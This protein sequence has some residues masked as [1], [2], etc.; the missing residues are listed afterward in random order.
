MSLI[1]IQNIMS[2]CI[3]LA[4]VLFID[5][6]P[7]PDEAPSEEQYLLLFA[8]QATNHRHFTVLKYAS[9]FKYLQMLLKLS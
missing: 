9:V 3:D 1:T 6:S 4:S 2:V 5:D 7:I 8:V